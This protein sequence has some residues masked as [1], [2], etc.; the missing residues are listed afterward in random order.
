MW[1][2][3]RI[4]EV[5][6][7][8]ELDPCTVVSNPVGAMRYYTPD[9]DGIL[10]PW[11][12]ET[13]YVN[14]PYGKTIRHW[15]EKAL[16]AAQ[17]GSRVLLLVPARTESKWFQASLRAADA[18][19]FLAGRLK[20]YENGLGVSSDA[21]FPSVLLAYNC[22]VDSLGDLGTIVWPLTPPDTLV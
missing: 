21:P 3:A 8:I 5:L 1:F 15:V 12:A 9:D 13:I 16:T 22:S 4:V 11:H 2:I 10:Q 6:G 19:L 14:P 20:F 17:L 18:A 7:H